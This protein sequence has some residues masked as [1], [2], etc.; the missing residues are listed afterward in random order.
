LEILKQLGIDPE[1]IV[2]NIV[3]FVVLL[4]I[5]KKFLYGPITKMFADRA[6]DIR[7]TY[8][9]AESEKAAMEKLRLDYE[10]RLADIEAEAREKIQA[11]IKE[12]QGAR[13]EIVSDA[14]EKADKLLQ[15]G[16]DELAREREKT[17]V[18]LRQELADLVVSASSKLVA[19]EMNDEAHRKLIDE[20]I[21]SIGSS[22]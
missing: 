16:E 8:E 22:K 20:F 4:L 9:A 11:A 18:A 14:K 12:A 15:R 7:S 2:V 3:G 6:D 17:I 10:K 21:S 19:R 1:L 5:L 13:D